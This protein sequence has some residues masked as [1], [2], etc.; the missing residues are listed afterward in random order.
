MF[1]NY[2]KTALRNLGRHKSN[3]FINAFLIASPIAWYLMHPWLEQY[4]YRIAF[5]LW[6]CVVTILC[7]LCIG[8]LTV[9]YTAIKAATANPVKSL[10]TE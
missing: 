7:S 10:R 2:L 4:T 8:W 1:R 9:G 3:S 5:G 6:F